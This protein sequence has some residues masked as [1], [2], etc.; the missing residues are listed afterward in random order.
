MSHRYA[1]FSS[2]TSSAV[3]TTS[4]FH[5]RP[6]C[7]DPG[8]AKP[9]PF[10]QLGRA[11]SFALACYLLA[12]SAGCGSGIFGAGVLQISPGSVDFG[13]V[14]VGQVADSSIA[15]S[16]SGLTPVSISQLSVAGATFSLAS[17]DKLPIRVMPG[18]THT[19]KVGFTP[20]TTD[21]YSGQLTVLDA[22]AKP[23]AQIAM[24][25]H[26]SR[27]AQLTVSA[28]RKSTRLNSSHSS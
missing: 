3:T 28:D 2:P 7:A 9:R 4:T 25:G 24:R 23:A 14:G 6:K 12:A 22:A 5:R 13:N 17:A 16:N 1:S 27:N 18:D 26:G 20:L 21:D 10:G 15:I 19:I 11:M 8:S